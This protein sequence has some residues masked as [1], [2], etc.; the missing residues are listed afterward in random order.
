MVSVIALLCAAAIARSDCSR[1]NAIDVVTLAEE[2]DEPAC[3]RDGMMILAALAIR[4]GSGE[5]WKVVC[6]S[7]VPRAPGAVV[8]HRERGPPGR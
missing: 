2:T 1:Q 3:L 4:A 6:E 8:T 7:M 5:Y